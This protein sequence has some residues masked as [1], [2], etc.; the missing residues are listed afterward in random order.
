MACSRL[1]TLAW[2]G[3]TLPTPTLATHTK[4]PHGADA[5]ASAL[6]PWAWCHQS[7]PSLTHIH[8]Y[9][10]IHASRWYRAPELL[11]GARKYDF[12]VDMWAVGAIFAELLANAPLFPGEND[13]NQIYRVMQVLG[14]PSV[15]IWPVTWS[16]GS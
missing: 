4:S 10:Y 3:C 16:V 14:T 15:D 7:F 9:T 13:I 5:H 8:T 11:F 1:Q 12:A 2:L 6:V